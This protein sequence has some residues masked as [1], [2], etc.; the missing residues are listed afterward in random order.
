MTIY[1]PNSVADISGFDYANVP[2][3]FYVYEDS[4]AHLY[5][6]EKN[7]KFVLLCVIKF[8]SNGSTSA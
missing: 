8:N 1:F 4:A 5:A 6:V 7:I 3:T 2:H